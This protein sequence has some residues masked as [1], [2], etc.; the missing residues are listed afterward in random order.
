M[1]LQR[2]S[3]WRDGVSESDVTLFRDTMERLSQRSLEVYRETAHENAALFEMFEKATPIEELASARFG[4]RPAYRPG[5]ASGIDGIRAIPWV[6]GWTQNRLM[7]PGWLGAGTALDEIA[8][9]SGGLELLGRMAKTWPFFDD[10]LAKIEMVCA[11]ADM[12]IA[13]TYVTRLGGDSALLSQ[14]TDEFEKTVNTLMKVRGADH[15]LD[16]SVVVQAAIALRNPY[17]DALSLLQ[18]NQLIRKRSLPK[19]ATEEREKVESVLATT[20]SG[21]AQGL[22]NTG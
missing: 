6:F 9:E 1:L 13:R 17:V 20:V 5:G 3:D 14:L 16:D 11:K 19:S 15:L 12:E 22:R 18:I 21:I 2:F 10:L 4:S 8:T 7:L